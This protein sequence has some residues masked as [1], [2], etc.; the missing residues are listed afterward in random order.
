MAVLLPWKCHVT[1]NYHKQKLAEQNPLWK[2]RV[3]LCELE[4]T[5]EGAMLWKM[6]FKKYCI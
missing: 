4:Q 2:R 5:Y 1:S 6:S 3:L